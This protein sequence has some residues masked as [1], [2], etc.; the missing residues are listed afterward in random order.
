M[1]QMNFHKR[2]L[3]ALLAAGIALVS[4]LL[5]WVTVSFLG[6]SQSAN[7]FQGWGLLSFLG[8][9]GVAG[10]SFLGNKTIDYTPEFKKYVMIAFAAIV[11][12]AIL[13]LLRKNSI[14]GGL[15]SDVVKTGIGLWICLI[16][17]L[18]GLAL[19]YG[20]IKTATTDNHPTV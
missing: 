15:F 16:A 14:N 4:L 1:E 13:F 5:P 19:I 7:G 17:G 3:Y 8:I 12:G 6:A 2:K 11:L 10:L 9:L 18:A 20:L